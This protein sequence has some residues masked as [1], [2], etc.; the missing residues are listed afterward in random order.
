MNEPDKRDLLIKSELLK[1]K[2]IRLSVSKWWIIVDNF[3]AGNKKA[4]DAPYYFNCQKC[5]S[6]KID[7]YA[8]SCQCNLTNEVAYF[9]C[10]DC[11][12]IMK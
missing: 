12:E 2:E 4:L 1:M 9:Y 8:D 6:N 5:G 7:L 10:K 11:G 3:C